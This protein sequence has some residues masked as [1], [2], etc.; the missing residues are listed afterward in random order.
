MKVRH[1][2][3]QKMGETRKSIIKMLMTE[4][5]ETNLGPPPEDS[6][7]VRAPSAEDS[8][9]QCFSR[10]RLNTKYIFRKSI[11]F[12]NKF[13]IILP[14][15]VDRTLGHRYRVT[16]D[17]EIIFSIL[18]TYSFLDNIPKLGWNQ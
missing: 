18:L 8:R 16:G 1:A 2:P 13:P 9:R 17:R 14:R 5:M 11:W 7:R 15:F 4:V 3:S 6:Q 10:P 12:I